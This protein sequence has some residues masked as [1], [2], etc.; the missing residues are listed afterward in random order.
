VTRRCCCR[1][2]RAS[3]KQLESLRRMTTFDYVFLGRIAN[4]LIDEVREGNRVTYNMTS[5]PWSLETRTL[6]R[7]TSSS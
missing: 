7:D 2:V 6:Q 3:W 5:K 1:C 4:R